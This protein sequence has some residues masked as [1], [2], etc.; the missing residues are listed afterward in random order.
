MFD[1]GDH[2]CQVRFPVHSSC[3][4]SRRAELPFDMHPQRNATRTKVTRGLHERNLDHDKF[5][6]LFAL[7]DPTNACKRAGVRISE[8]ALYTLR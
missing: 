5:G 6:E 7:R 2:I 4:A 8:D 3:K 1:A